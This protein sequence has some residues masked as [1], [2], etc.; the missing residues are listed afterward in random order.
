MGRGR[1]RRPWKAPS[2]RL[3]LERGFEQVEGEAEKGG[4]QGKHPGAMT[5]GRVAGRGKLGSVA[6][7]RENLRLVNIYLFTG[8][9][10]AGPLA[11][12]EALARLPLAPDPQ[13][14]SE[15]SS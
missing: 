7:G 3:V 6:E 14:L 4:R 12:V 13:L 11:Q 9:M 2:P 1:G 5:A 15:L 8:D 10:P